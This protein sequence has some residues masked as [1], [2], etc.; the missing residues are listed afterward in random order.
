MSVR[1]ACIRH[2]A[3]VYPEPGSNSPFDLAHYFL[4]YFSLF[5]QTKFHKFIDVCCL[6]SGSV[7]KDHSPS[8]LRLRA[9]QDSIAFALTCQHLFFISFEFLF[10]ADP[11]FPSA[12]LIYHYHFLIAR[13]FFI[14]FVYVNPCI[15]DRKSLSFSG[16]T[17]SGYGSVFSFPLF[18]QAFAVSFT[19]LLEDIIRFFL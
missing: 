3:S 9:N 4:L 15:S 11:V 14:F 5:L 7:F 12:F 1:L 8:P 2:A 10:D 18:Y 6:I 19:D 17:P 13:S 16:Q